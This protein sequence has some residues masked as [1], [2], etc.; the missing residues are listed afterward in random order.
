MHS[1]GMRLYAIKIPFLPWP[2]PAPVPFPRDNYSYWFLCTLWE[3]FYT[4]TINQYFIC[5]YLVLLLLYK[6]RI[7]KHCSVPC[8]IHL[9]HFRDCSYQYTKRC[10]SLCLNS[11]IMF[12]S[13]NLAYLTNF[14]FDEYFSCFQSF[15]V[16]SRIVAEKMQYIHLHTRLYTI[17]WSY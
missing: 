1:N 4:C 3:I 5:L 17:T 6:Y 8:F 9:I 2:S 15:A 7:L 14:S 11:Y 10:F 12:H 16:I 13:I